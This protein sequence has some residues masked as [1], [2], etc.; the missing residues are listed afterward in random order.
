MKKYF[1]PILMGVLI[2][3]GVI[4]TV[5]P[6]VADYLMPAKTTSYRRAPA[7][8]AQEALANWFNVRP[9]EVKYSEAIQY[10]TP[11]QKTAWFKFTIERT[12][13]EQFIRS[14]RLKQEDLTSEVMQQRFLAQKPPVEWWQPAELTRQTYFTGVSA[15]QELNLIYNADLKQGYLLIHTPNAAP[16]TP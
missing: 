3:F 8:E 4:L 9:S 1:F 5:T 14:L 10:R 13:V 16:K 15:G 11:T 2:L 7:P 12:P 6:W